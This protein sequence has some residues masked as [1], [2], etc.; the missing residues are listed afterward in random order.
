MPGK[1]RVLPPKAHKA[2]VM[3]TLLI[4]RHAKS[5]WDNATINDIDR[6]LNDRGKR[7]APAM[8]KRLIKAGVSIDRFVSSPAKRARHTAEIFLDQ[9]ERKEKELVIVQP[10]YH[11]QVQDFREVVAGLDD[12]YNSIALFSHN[13]GI[14]TF[15][16]MLSTVRLD[17]MPTCSIFAVT[18]AADS[19]KDF[20]STGTTFCFFD[21]PKSIGEKD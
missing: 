1:T 17:N 18:G 4:V 11:A 19:W 20:L 13:P 14:T 8:A 12:R 7:D 9:F 16:N 5:S 2:S 10:L 15:A 3:K 21:Y 6:P